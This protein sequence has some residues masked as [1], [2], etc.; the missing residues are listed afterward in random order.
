M[1]MK[2]SNNLI[3]S[4]KHGA[5]VTTC[6]AMIVLR[7]SYDQSSTEEVEIF[8]QI[9]QFNSDRNDLFGADWMVG[10]GTG[11]KWDE[12]DDDESQFNSFKI[13]IPIP[14]NE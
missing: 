10:H 9:V 6:P 13:P 14:I 8:T 11:G 1:D 2:F 7:K 3:E 12:D 4:I 5:I